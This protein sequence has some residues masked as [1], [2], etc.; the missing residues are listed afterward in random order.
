ML[1]KLS[2][3]LSMAL[4][5]LFPACKQVEVVDLFDEMKFVYLA[6]KENG[7]GYQ[8]R[9]EL[10][11]FRK[12]SAFSKRDSEALFEEFKIDRYVLTKFF[13][14]ADGSDLVET[15]RYSAPD[16]I[17]GD[18]VGKEFL[19]QRPSLDKVDLMSYFFIEGASLYAYY[20]P[21]RVTEVTFEDDY[22]ANAIVSGSGL[23][24][25]AIVLPDDAAN[26]KVHWRLPEESDKVV[27]VFNPETTDA[28]LKLVAMAPGSYEI[29]V[30]TD[31]GKLAKECA[32][33]VVPLSVDYAEF[34]P[35][36]YLQ[37]QSYLQEV[38]PDDLGD[39]SLKWSSR[40]PAILQFDNESDSKLGRA[41]GMAAGTARVVAADEER[42]Y[43]FHL[44][45]VVHSAT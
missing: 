37:L 39:V 3:L 6:P 17:S 5:L 28:V 13:L 14:S 38:L 34:Y 9:T 11:S 27:K 41:H 2:Y 21:I 22:S 7:D 32:I 15:G 36:Y 35:T 10:V 4:L 40:D 25:K 42:G 44:S 24:V 23:N 43:E 45:V 20:D 12:G 26:R 16:S 30:V 31:D 1:R 29:E 19:R 18:M 33:S 8:V